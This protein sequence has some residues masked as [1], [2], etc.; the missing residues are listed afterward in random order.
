M[1]FGLFGLTLGQI[2][3]LMLYLIAGVL[4]GVFSS[5]QSIF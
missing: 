3:N 2:L 1:N 4:F 5:R